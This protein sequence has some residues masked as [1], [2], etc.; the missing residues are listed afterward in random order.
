MRSAAPRRATCSA[1][2]PA[3]RRARGAG[4]GRCG[5]LPRRGADRRLRGGACRSSGRTTQPWCTRTGAAH[6]RSG[7]RPLAVLL[8]RAPDVE[9]VFAVSDLPAVGALMECHRRGIRVP[10][11]L[12]LIGFGDFEIGRQCVPALTT[13]PVDARDIG[14]RTGELLLRLLD[15]KAGEKDGGAKTDPEARRRGFRARPARDDGTRRRRARRASTKAERSLHH[16]PQWLARRRGRRGC[17]GARPSPQGCSSVGTGVA[18]ATPIPPG[19][20]RWPPAGPGTRAAAA[21]LAAEVDYIVISL[22]T[23]EI[24]ER[25]VFGPE[26][27]AAGAAPA[28]C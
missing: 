12:S 24:V 22:N 23:A 5:R 19:R 21:T 16:E 18:C 25:V 3:A 4:R 6:L 13:I 9:A 7:R 27:I 26:G 15:S 2:P 14:L 28:S 17:H 20:R 10:R 11:E 1:G 8:E